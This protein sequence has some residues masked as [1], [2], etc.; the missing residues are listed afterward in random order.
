VTGLSADYETVKRQAIK[1]IQQLESGAHSMN[2]QWASRIKGGVDQLVWCMT[3]EPGKDHENLLAR[4][5]I[6]IDNVMTPPPAPPGAMGEAFGALADEPEK[7]AS[8]PFPEGERAYSGDAP[9]RS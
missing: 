2:A 8:T 7:V 9:S 3:G 5:K 6:A 1:L 4:M